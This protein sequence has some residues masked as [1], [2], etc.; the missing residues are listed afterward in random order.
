VNIEL[1]DQAKEDIT[2]WNRVDPARTAKVQRLLASVMQTPYGGLGK[3]EPL[4]YDLAGYWSR[5][6]THEH[7]L[8]YKVEDDT[9][10]VVSCRYHYR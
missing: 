2:Y 3:P 6:I 7:R 10:Y 8:V 9:L 5:R 1:S 4:Q